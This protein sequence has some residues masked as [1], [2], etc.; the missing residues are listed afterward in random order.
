MHRGARLLG[1][2]VPAVEAE[3]EP[4]ERTGPVDDSA[5]RRPAPS[6]F[7]TTGWETRR[8]AGRA[9]GSPGTPDPCTLPVPNVTV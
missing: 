9:G 5:C 4:Y 3:P 7:A 2:L 6:R 8:A 1:R